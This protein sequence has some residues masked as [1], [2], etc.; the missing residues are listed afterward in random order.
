MS[1]DHIINSGGIRLA[2]EMFGDGDPLIFAHGL[3]GNRQHTQRQ[4]SPLGDSF[5]IITYDQRGHGASTPVTQAA[6]YTADAMAEDMARILDHLGID[7]AI[8]GGESM[9]AATTLTF[10]L[11]YPHRVQQL[12]LTGPAFGDRPNREAQRLQ[13]LGTLI[14]TQ[15]MDACLAGMP[16]R[17]KQEQGA[18]D[19][20]ISY[21]TD[22]WHSHD[23]QSL[24]VAL[25]AVSTWV[26]LQDLDVLRQL[27]CPVKIIAWD[28]DPLHSLQLAEKF[29]KTFPNSTLETIASLSLLFE[30]PDIIG[31]TYQ[32]MLTN[33]QP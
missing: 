12:L 11:K 6:M 18:S 22:M 15:G 4:L 29:H 16:A 24:A 21:I 10:A 13:L 17:M 8:V 1:T 20:V 25:Q 33:M 28:G 23:P 27:D 31:K 5:T 7:S 14:Q 32:A 2:V 3:T 19:D 26:I 30:Q 9:G